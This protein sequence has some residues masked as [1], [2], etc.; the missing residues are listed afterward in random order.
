VP[1]DREAPVSLIQNS[2]GAGEIAPGLYGRTDLAKVHQGAALMRNFFVDY[3]GG[4]A[5]R[6]GTQYIGTA[7]TSGRVRLVPFIFSGAIGQSY[8][9]VFAAYT[10]RFI[11]A[12]GTASHP[13]GSDAGFIY[14]AGFP[15]QLDTPYLEVDLPHLK[16]SQVG[17]KMVITRQGYPRQLLSR[18]GDTSWTLTEVVSSAGPPAPTITEITLTAPDTAANDPETTRYLY[19]VTTVDADGIESLPSAPFISAPGLNIATTQGTVSVFWTAVSEA[20]FYRV[21]K[22][23][24]TTTDVVPS[25][26][27]QLGYA[28]LSYGT[29]FADP[30]VVPDFARSPPSYEN[31]FAD[32]QIIG[33]NITASSS[34]WPV[35]G[36]TLS[37][38][39]ST[40]SGALIYPILSN[41][42]AG[43]NGAITGLYI[44]NRGHDYTSP[45][46]S[47]SG[48][49]TTF[50]ATL[51]I[52]PS[53]GNDPDVV[54]LFQQR[55]VYASS[56]NFPITLWASRPSR[57]NDFRV[58]NPIIDSDAYTFSIAAAKV[59]KIVWMQYMPGGLVIATNSGIHQL[60][61]G[62][63][64]KAVTPTDA[65]IIPQSFAGAADLHPLTID[66]DILYVQAQG[67]V[68]RDLQYQ[69][70][71]NIYTGTDITA[72]SS[73]LFYPY[74]IS[75]WDYQDTPYKLIWAVQNNGRI[76]SCAW[77]KAQEVIGWSQHETQG[78][79]EDIAVVREGSEDA[80]YFSV[81]R[82]GGYRYIERLAG[83]IYAQIDDAWC[84]DS[85]LA[86]P[87]FYPGMNLSLSG[88]T[89][90]GVH[91]FTDA[92]LF[93][94]S[95]EGGV[96]RSA[97]AKA[98]LDTYVGPREMIG[99]VLYPF[100]DNVIG[101]G[102]WRLDALL[103]SVTGLGHLDGYEVW[104]LA[105]GVV[106]GP[107]TV[108]GGSID[109]TTPATQ[110]VVGIRYVCQ[111]QP[112]YLD[113]GGE[114]T[115]QGRLKKVTAATIRVTDTAR[116]KFGSDFET[117]A[118]WRPAYATD[119]VE[120]WYYQGYGMFRGDMRAYLSPIFDTV[121]SVC[122]QQDF[123]LPATILAVI[124]EVA[125]GDLS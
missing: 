63:Q 38:T 109:L 9:L 22:A 119:P 99:T 3:R 21:Y 69:Q 86:A 122:I 68:V 116:L 81:L 71:Y 121:G 34:D 55:Q 45:T 25:K 94:P 101:A 95:W 12:S 79:V 120:P 36:T 8:M 112:L 44:V 24:P 7:G 56:Y 49:G 16:F 62:G 117:L 28:G 43:E 108:A 10:L 96:I 4:A 61:A 113:T 90:P 52:S 6:P 88:L 125:Q 75:S 80:V 29:V 118:E 35:E 74:V 54:S 76:L 51:E 18:F 100:G 111:I 104:A 30:N 50:T 46:V 106:Q 58:T 91:F 26:S 27:A 41:N 60:T 89:G 37:V 42:K 83:R 92:D 107:F 77:M 67:G 72:L 115:T 23:L 59:D 33:Y 20:A 5:T 78:T 1:P 13:N 82:S 103:W 2:L 98:R 105:D 48:G 47:A 93:N 57:F 66:Y 123:P 70:Y 84:L 64:G 65:A 102:A 110:V 39:D 15:Y 124:P 40:G 73:H 53:T 87:S 14:D 11:K 32:A 31:P 114:A 19:A 17:D 85:A 97:F